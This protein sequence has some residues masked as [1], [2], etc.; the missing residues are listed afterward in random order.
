MRNRSSVRL[1]RLA[2]V[3]GLL[4]AWG[5]SACSSS[6]SGSGSGSTAGDGTGDSTSSGT[7]ALS[8]TFK[9]TSAGALAEISFF[10]P[11][12]YALLRGP[13]DDTAADCPET[14][15]YALS[16]DATS[17][18]LTPDDGGA[19]SELP[20]ASLLA[21][22]A[23]SDGTLTTQSESLRALE[24]D[25][26]VSGTTSLVCKPTT[27]PLVQAASVAGQQLVQTAITSPSS[28]WPGCSGSF[29]THGSPSGSY[30]VTD[31]GCSGSPSFTDSEDNCCGAGVIQAASQGLC[32]AGTSTKGCS[33]S[34]GTSA[35]IAC[36]RAVNWFATGGSVFG[37]GARLQLTSKSGKSVVVFVIDNG[38]AC[39]RERQFGGY[40][41]DVSYPTVKYL[42]GSEVGTSDHAEVQV[43]A[44]DASTPLGP[45]T[46]GTTPVTA[47]DSGTASGGGGGD[48]DGGLNGLP[49]CAPSASCKSDGDCNPGSNGSGLV[50]TS[51]RCVGG[52][53]TS[54]QCPGSSTC[55][56]GQCTGGGSSTTPPATPTKPASPGG[57][58]CTSDGSCNP[59]NDGAGLVCTGG[60][61][62]AGC[63]ANWYCPGNLTCKNG[64]CG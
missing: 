5:A 12:R 36:E 37:N 62:A 29:D 60:T 44:V 30:F 47:A 32:A 38:P 59:G 51:G 15:D 24:P 41:I 10:A 26:L 53:R 3:A 52:C 64:Q 25:D 63:K 14:G 35:S 17:L 8:G 56:S 39:Y 21:G 34:T 22:E 54:A 18:T 58:A 1:R 48:G 20:F 50:C 27:G 49:V 6:S 55:S 61:C 4:L 40:A 33:G 31:F 16:A 45:V 23:E 43:K 46:G 7:P 42:F 9:A 57:K 19:P 13:C 11:A 28:G 2:A